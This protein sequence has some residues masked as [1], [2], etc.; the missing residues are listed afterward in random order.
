MVHVSQNLIKRAFRDPHGINGDSP[1][2]WAGPGVVIVT[3][4]CYI[5][6]GNF[7]RVEGL[8][9]ELESRSLA[10]RYQ[11][12][13][14]LVAEAA[15]KA[16][17]SPESIRLVAVSKYVP[18]SS[19]REAH[20]LGIQDFGESRVQDALPKR[21]E[22]SDLDVRWHFIGHLQTN[23]VSR[24]VGDFLLIHSVDS[25]RLAEAL[26]S[27]ARARGVVQSILLQVNTSGE[28][29]KYG[30]SPED[31]PALLER[32]LQAL[33]HLRVEGLMTMAP[34]AATAEASRPFFRRLRELRD[35]LNERLPADRRL[36]QLSMGM[37]QDFTVAVEEGAT[38]IR[39]G[40]GLFGT[41][42]A[43]S[44]G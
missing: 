17:R 10:D 35:A 44:P 8:D 42:P 28:S 23:K 37:S 22:L 14:S 43:G 29:S 7:T 34:R 27:E 36:E 20:A 25:W 5:F 11:R 33:P 21:D 6:R 1:H 38:L 39:I 12:I 15:H 4:K 32:V 9:S 13:R 3:G 40:S 18:A 24:V 41:A 16:G 2:R 26:D 19:V 31:A 30:T